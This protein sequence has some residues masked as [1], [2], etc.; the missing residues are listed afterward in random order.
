VTGCYFQSDRVRPPSKVTLDD[1][2]G[3]RL[4]TVSAELTGLAT[5][6]E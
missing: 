5:P 3:D 2:A 4:Y 6:H 1:A